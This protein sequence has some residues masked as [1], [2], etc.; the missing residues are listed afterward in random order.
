MVLPAPVSPVMT[1][2][3]GANG[4][5][6]R[7]IRTRFSIR[8]L[9]SKGLSVAVEEGHLGQQRQQ[10]APPTE[11]YRRFLSFPELGNGHAVDDHLRIRRPCLVPHPQL[12]PARD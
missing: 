11:L 5:S 9:R 12:E 6:A 8:R 1:F 10:R 7:R 2:K 4:R 3:P